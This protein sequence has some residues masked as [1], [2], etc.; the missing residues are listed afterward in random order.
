MPRPVLSGRREFEVCGTDFGEFCHQRYHELLVLCFTSAF[1][2]LC[3]SGTG[4]MEGPVSVISHTAR[5]VYVQQLI[6]LTFDGNSFGTLHFAMCLSI[7]DGRWRQLLSEA[8]Q[9]IGGGAGLQPPT[10]CPEAAHA[11]PPPLL[12]QAHVPFHLP[13]APCLVPLAPLALGAACPVESSSTWAASTWLV[14]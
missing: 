13:S 5:G 1:Q 2:R 7:V 14:F 9:L 12:P 8:P 11:A 4:L 10:A 6:K 3:V